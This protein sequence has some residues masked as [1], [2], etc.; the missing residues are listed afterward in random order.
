MRLGD[1]KVNQPSSTSPSS[2]PKPKIPTEHGLKI[3]RR[4]SQYA[5][6]MLKGEDTMAKKCKSAKRAKKEQKKKCKK[7]NWLERF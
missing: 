3:A 7:G 2:S 6:E 5:R 1:V 4:A